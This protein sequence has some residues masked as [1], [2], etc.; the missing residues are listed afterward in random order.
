[1]QPSPLIPETFH[2]PKKESCTHQQSLTILP[3]PLP[4]ATTNLLLSLW[5]CLFWTFQSSG[6]IQYVIF[7]VWLLLSMFSKVRPCCSMYQYSILLYGLMIFH[8]MDIHVLFTHSSM[9]KHLG[10]FSFLAIML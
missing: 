4:L 9:G 6:I 8:C 1:M 7:Y 5:I 10:C 2:H 3:F